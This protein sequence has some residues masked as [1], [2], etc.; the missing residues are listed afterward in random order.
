MDGIYPGDRATLDYGWLLSG[1]LVR[2]DDVI[3]TGGHLVGPFE[4]NPHYWNMRLLP[5]QL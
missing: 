1:L 5:N 4:G 3:N 2:D